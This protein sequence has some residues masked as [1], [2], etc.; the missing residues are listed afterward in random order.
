MLPPTSF[1]S[2]LQCLENLFKELFQVFFFFFKPLICL[3]KYPQRGNKDCL[4]AVTK[5]GNGQEKSFQYT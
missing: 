1:V 3:Q 5:G 4:L 2:F